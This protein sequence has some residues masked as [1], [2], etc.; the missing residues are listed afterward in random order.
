MNN[1]EATMPESQ[2]M[3][4]AEAMRECNDY[5][6]TLHYD[7]GW[8][9]DWEV[10]IDPINGMRATASAHATGDTWPEAVSAALGRPVV[11]RDDSE[12][13]KA[14]VE[15]ALESQSRLVAQIKGMNDN[16]TELVEAI[17]EF[18]DS[19]RALVTT[20]KPTADLETRALRALTTLQDIAHKHRATLAAVG[21]G[22]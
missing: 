14:V 2:V 9:V 8:F 3:T 5:G 12:W 10:D 1:Q 20:F 6:M 16:R 13:N 17:V 11:E 22:E 21:E 7:G 18:V 19:D 4:L 15:A